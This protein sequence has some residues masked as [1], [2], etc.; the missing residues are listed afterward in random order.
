MRIIPNQF[1][2]T[3]VRAL[4]VGAM[5]AAAGLTAVSPAQA[6][7]QTPD[8]GPAIDAFASYDPQTTCSPTPKAGVT[9]FRDILNQAYGSHTGYISRDCADGGTSE[10]KEGRALDYMLD[11]NNS[12]DHADANDILTWL[13]A[14]DKYGNKNAMARR[15][16][17]M[18]VIWDRQIWGSYKADEGWRPYTG[19]NPHT[20]H[21]HFSFSWAGAKRQTTWWTS[22]I[23]QDSVGDYNGDGQTDRALFR[24]STGE[25][26]IQYYR[27]NGVAIYTWGQAG[28]IPVPGDY[29]GDGQFDRAVFRPSTGQWLIQYYGSNGTAAYTW[30]QA[31]DIPVPGDYNGDGQYDRALFRPSTGQWLIQYYR[32]NGTA[33]YTWGQ[34]GDIPVPG[35]YNGDGQ[36]DRAVFRPSTGQWLIQY[37]G[38]NGTAAYTWG[39]QG[40]IPVT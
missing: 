26:R 36:F 6:A 4:V 7:P 12:A 24:P 19:T 10:H 38:S 22:A 23:D 8:F 27:T 35:D 20:D 32:T 29:N 33:I 1:G 37:Y 15:L 5:L 13:L 17:I 21:I 31:G 30:G 34:D 28:D 16:G 40:D 3:L 39:Q 2:R 18:Y 25:W 11:I 9:G 14:T